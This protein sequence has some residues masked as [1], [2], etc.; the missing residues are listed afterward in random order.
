MPIALY[1]PDIP[2]NVGSILRL[3]ACMETPCHIIGPCGFAFDERK[4]KRVAMDY[5]DLAQAR[6]HTS[7]EAFNGWRAAAPARLILLT[8]K[9][10]DSLY[11]FT[12]RPDD[13]LLLGRES[14]GVPPEVAETCDARLRIPISANTRSLNIALAAAIALGE[15]K[16]QLAL[17]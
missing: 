7:W 11:D 6:Q 16:R 8:T 4:L 17:V 13:I 9:S 3:A 1:Q 2:Q 14:A 12:F 10:A 5:I 15:A